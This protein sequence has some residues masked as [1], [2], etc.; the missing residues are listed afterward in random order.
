MFHTFLVHHTRTSH[1]AHEPFLIEAEK[2]LFI[3]VGRGSNANSLLDMSSSVPLMKLDYP[4]IRTL[5]ILEATLQ[6]KLD[7][8]QG[9]IQVAYWSIKY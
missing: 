1:L 2:Y 6:Y 9:W 3:I 8:L 4:T 5:S 7:L